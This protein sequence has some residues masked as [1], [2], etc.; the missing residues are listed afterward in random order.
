MWE[1]GEYNETSNNCRPKWEWGWYGEN[2]DSQSWSHHR[3]Y[4]SEG[5]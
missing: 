1:K 3:E 4:P 2:K 5:E